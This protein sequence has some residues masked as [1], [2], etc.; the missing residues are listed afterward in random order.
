MRKK[1]LFS[2]V[3]MVIA[4]ILLI[5]SGESNFKLDVVGSTS[6][7]PVCEELVEEYKKTHPDVDINVQGGG[8]SLGIKC[9]ENSLADIGMSSKEVNCSDLDVYEI[10]IE[11]IVVVV[12][13][14]N[15]ISD[16]SCGEIRDIF[17]GEIKNWDEISNQSGKINVIVREEGSGTLDAFKEIIMNGSEIKKDAII[18][19]SAGAVKQSVI[20]DK[21]AIGF[22]SLSHLDKDIKPISIG[23]INISE[24]SLRDGSYGLQRPFL[25]L[26]N[27][28]PNT[29]T[30]EFIN[31]TLSD[32]S[33]EIFEK[34]MIYKFD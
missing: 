13:P 16:L 25:L 4:L 22:V 20:Q 7:Q 6:V 17:S 19:N 3:V 12:N 14:K 31:W 23:G 2:L 28:T 18:Q 5:P 33:V 10:G 34:E 1:Y 27:K 24:E 26:T 21:D 9:S 15:E 29:Q 32:E 30:M 11:G 8:S